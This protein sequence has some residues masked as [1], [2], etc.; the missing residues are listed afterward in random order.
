M[1]GLDA[2]GKTSKWYRVRSWRSKD[3]F[4]V[5]IREIQALVMNGTW[6]GTRVRMSLDDHVL[7]LGGHYLLCRP[8][9]LPRDPD[10][11]PSAGVRE[12]RED[13]RWPVDCSH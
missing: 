12:V 7:S 3:S 6:W 1:L 13:L 4:G 2:A 8:F 9:I 11:D 5:V 10:F